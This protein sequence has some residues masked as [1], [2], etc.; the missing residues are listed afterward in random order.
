MNEKNV[1]LVSVELLNYKNVIKGKLEMPCAVNR[2]F[3]CDRAEILGIYG[4]N[5]SGKTAVIE[6]LSLV[7]ALLS[8]QPLPLSA[9]DGI[10][11]NSEEA[12]IAVSFFLGDENEGILT[13]YQFTLRRIEEDGTPS[14]FR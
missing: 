6:V 8:G 9:E 13:K 4:Q 5:G 10:A 7:K 1:R 12:V 3:S 14:V 11:K 2:D